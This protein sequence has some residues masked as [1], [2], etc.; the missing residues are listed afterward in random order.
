MSIH[1]EILT[2]NNQIKH[3]DMTSKPRNFACFLIEDKIIFP[4]SILFYPLNIDLIY[5]FYFFLI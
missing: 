1:G 3:L 4:S 5:E 2:K